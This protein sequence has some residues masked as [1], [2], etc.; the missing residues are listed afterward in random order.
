MY[1]SSH[2]LMMMKKPWSKIRD[3]EASIVV[4]PGPYTDFPLDF[5]KTHLRK[6]EHF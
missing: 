1:H 4:G 2:Q 3:G 6:S 5:F